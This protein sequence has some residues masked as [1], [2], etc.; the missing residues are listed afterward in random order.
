MGQG[1]GRGQGS[2]RTTYLHASYN[3]DGLAVTVLVHELQFPTGNE[4]RGTERRVDK[5]SVLTKAICY[6]SLQCV[7]RRRGERWELDGGAVKRVAQSEG[8]NVRE[9]LVE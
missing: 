7:G 1:R 8:T 3:C 9:S 6:S 5:L 2:L 4:R